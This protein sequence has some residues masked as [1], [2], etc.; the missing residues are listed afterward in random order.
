MRAPCSSPPPPPFC[1][2]W[3]ARNY[4][5]GPRR[6]RVHPTAGHPLVSSHVYLSNGTAAAPAWL[7]DDGRC[8][9][10]V[11][12][13]VTLV[14]LI[15]RGL[16]KCPI[17]HQNNF[18][19]LQSSPIIWQACDYYSLGQL[20]LHQLPLNTQESMSYHNRYQV[21]YRPLYQMGLFLR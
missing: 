20:W 12:F 4:R 7:R 18:L 13:A 17:R 5:D 2:V 8:G 19:R 15:E 11:S 21:L 3:A 16:K 14:C 10:A 6:S 9:N 1:R